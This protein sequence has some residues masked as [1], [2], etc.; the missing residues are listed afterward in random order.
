MPEAQ[1]PVIAAN[2]RCGPS[3]DA[4]FTIRQAVPS[5]RGEARNGT[6][7]TCREHERDCLECGKYPVFRPGSLDFWTVMR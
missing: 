4:F 6:E 7:K 1:M 5:G 2:R 3:L